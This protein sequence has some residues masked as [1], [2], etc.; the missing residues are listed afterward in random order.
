MYAREAI[1]SA[2]T[3]TRF[4]TL[5]REIRKRA[6]LTQLQLAEHL[7]IDKS[8]VSKLETGVSAPPQDPQFYDRL[9]AVPGFSDSDITCLSIVSSNTA[10]DYEPPKEPQPFRAEVLT[11][12]MR[13]ILP[14]YPK[15]GRVEE[16]HVPVTKSVHTV[17]NTLGTITR[18]S[19]S[20]I[21]DFPLTIVEH[22]PKPLPEA[23][24]HTSVPDHAPKLVREGRRFQTPKQGIVFDRSD[25]KL[26]FEA[27]GN[28]DHAL[29]PAAEQAMRV[30][31]VAAQRAGVI[32]SDSST[33]EFT[34]RNIYEVVPTLRQAAEKIG[35]PVEE[36]MTIRDIQAEWD[37]SRGRIQQLMRRKTQSSPH[38]TPLSVR[39]QSFGGL[40][41]YRR[42]E[43]ERTFAD[44]NV[45]IAKKPEQ[46]ET[47]PLD[48]AQSSEV[49]ATLRQ[50]A[51]RI[52]VPLNEIMTTR[53]IL[54]DYGVNRSRINRWIQSPQE[55]PRLTPLHFKLQGGGIGGQYLFRRS[56]IERILADPPQGGRPSS[57]EKHKQEPAG[58]TQN[59]VTIAE[60]TQIS[61]IK[62]S[63]L[64][65]YISEG[66]LTVRGRQTY[67][68]PGGGKLLLD[69]DE[70]NSFPRRS[71]GRPKKPKPEVD[72]PY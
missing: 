37:V 28:P 57:L 59:L 49:V 12:T 9:R 39:L 62:L 69:L 47:Q 56:D 23:Y 25:A 60:A 18:R 43:V 29:S 42:S 20:T 16:S 71:R 53:D 46:P 35:V 31:T 65:K 72:N 19:P 17:F 8:R 58:S 48:S 36:I 24:P 4:G 68:A 40:L 51:E 11:Q 3:K 14:S 45:A 22:I 50:A 54:A 27:L 61:G 52:G 32:T 70:L 44:P 33:Q 67:P 64:Y 30:F 7:A 15:I 66:K 63:T 21:L 55:Q 5:L 34:V 2:T 26:F 13:K 1:M 6:G 41:L 38:L 10:W